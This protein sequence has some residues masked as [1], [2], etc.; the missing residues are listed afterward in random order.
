MN[1]DV[2]SHYSYTQPGFLKNINNIVKFFLRL[3]KWLKVEKV[4]EVRSITVPLYGVFSHLEMKL[5]TKYSLKL[6]CGQDVDTKFFPWFYCR[7]IP[8]PTVRCL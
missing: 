1:S 7:C 4:D 5:F 6:D 2:F 3:I 8:V